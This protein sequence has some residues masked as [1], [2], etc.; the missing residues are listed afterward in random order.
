MSDV[1]EPHKFGFKILAGF[2]AVFVVIGSVLGFLGL[3]VFANV[4]STAGFAGIAVG[5]VYYFVTLFL[6]N[7][8]TD[9]LL[10]VL[11]PQGQSTKKPK[12]YSQIEALV[13]Q[14]RFE[15]AAEA[16][17][18]EIETDPDDAEAM[19]RLARLYLTHL[20]S[21]ADAG[22]FLAK[23]RDAAVADKAKLGFS[24]QLVDLYRTKL[25]DPG[26]AMVELRRIIDTFPGTAQAE[27]AKRELHELLEARK[28]DLD[29]Q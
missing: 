28:A 10:A 9:G 21:P 26:R 2:G 19:H 20:D 1:T 3:G 16:Y 22:I 6:V 14:S 8:A 15:E 13:M 12:G 24:V 4:I 29:R 18:R 17:K 23:A 11:A 5:I 7:P 25:N 27:G